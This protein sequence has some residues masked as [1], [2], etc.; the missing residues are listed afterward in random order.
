MRSQCV[1]NDGGSFGVGEG[2]AEKGGGRGDQDNVV[3]G[4]FFSSTSSPPVTRGNEG[5]GQVRRGESPTSMQPQCDDRD[6][7]RFRG[8]EGQQEKGGGRG[9]HDNTV[10]S[11]FF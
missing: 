4:V 10:F 9:D 7:G 8:G 1:H 5:Q 3:C 11:D 6:G 2:Q